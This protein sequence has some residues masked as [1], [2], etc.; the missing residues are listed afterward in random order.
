MPKKRKHIEVPEGLV[1]DAADDATLTQFVFTFVEKAR[2]RKGTAA[3]PPPMQP[4]TRSSRSS[5]ASCTTP[6]ARRPWR[7]PSS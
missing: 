1:M 2:Q 3:P 6:R 4:R 5:W 7:W